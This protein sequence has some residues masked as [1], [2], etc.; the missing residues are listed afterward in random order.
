MDGR[1]HNFAVDQHRHGKGQGRGRVGVAHGS[2]FWALANEAKGCFRLSRL[3]GYSRLRFWTLSCLDFGSWC[4][5]QIPDPT[6]ASNFGLGCLQVLVL[7]KF[8]ALQI[9]RDTISGLFQSGWFDVLPVQAPLQP[10][11]RA[12]IKYFGSF[13]FSYVDRGRVR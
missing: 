3:E 5:F 1:R 11:L 7:S 9:L 13:K 12:M 8:H 10:P 6:R 4:Q 2:R